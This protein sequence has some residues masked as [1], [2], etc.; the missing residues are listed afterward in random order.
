[1]LV[2]IIER[3]HKAM[4]QKI[5]IKVHEKVVLKY[6]KCDISALYIMHW[7]ILQ[8]NEIVFPIRACTTAILLEQLA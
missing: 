5:I 2:L 6:V 3:V 7:A 4:F 1:M 8:D